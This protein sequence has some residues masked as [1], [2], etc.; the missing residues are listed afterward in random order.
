[1]LYITNDQL[2]KETEALLATGQVVD[3]T[4][5]ERCGRNP[6]PEKKLQNKVSLATIFRPNIALL[7]VSSCSTNCLSTL[8]CYRLCVNP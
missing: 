6:P 7:H 4:F 2:I 5:E 1:M 3:Y 8:Y